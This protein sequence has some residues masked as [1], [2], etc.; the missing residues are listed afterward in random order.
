MSTVPITGTGFVV[1]PGG[2]T[3]NNSTEYRI[4]S[5]VLLASGGVGVLTFQLLSD[6]ASS[7]TE[8]L[9]VAND[10]DSKTI[11]FKHRHKGR[12]NVT[13]FTNLSATGCYLNL[14]D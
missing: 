12:I 10:N 7:I 3:S 9:S 5:V 1:A 4:S 6:G 14:D 2:G 8:T 13:A 11:S